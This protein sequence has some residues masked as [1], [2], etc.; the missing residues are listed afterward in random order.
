MRIEG[1]STEAQNRPVGRPH[2]EISTG[3]MPTRKPP[4]IVMP[5]DAPIDREPE[6]ILLVDTA[7]EADYMAE[8]SFMEE[9]VTIRIERSAEKFAPQLLDFYVNGKVEW[10]PVGRP[11]TLRRKYVE[12]IARSQPYDVRTTTVKHEDREENKIQR[13]NVTKYP[14]SIIQDSPR[15]MQWIQRVMAES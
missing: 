7:P 3:D 1:Q 11:W 12:V 6:E 5:D 4:A 8:V 13:F 14:F 15:G 2:K 9:P 10:I